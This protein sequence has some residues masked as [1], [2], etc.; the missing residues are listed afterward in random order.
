MTRLGDLSPLGHH[1]PAFGNNVG[2]KFWKK[3]RILP[4]AIFGQL[5][6]Q[7]GDFLLKPTGHTEL[8]SHPFLR[9]RERK[10]C[11]AI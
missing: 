10:N 9:R 7:I 6:T 4:F 2:L 1:F 5:D 3:G 8:A 11:L